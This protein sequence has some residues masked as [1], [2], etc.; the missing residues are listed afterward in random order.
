MHLLKQPLRISTD[1]SNN[2]NQQILNINEL[3][4]CFLIQ[5]ETATKQTVKMFHVLFDFD[6]TLY[7][8]TE[9]DKIA[10]AKV[11]NYI[12]NIFPIE[13]HEVQIIYK[14]IVSVI[15]KSNNINNKHDKEIY[16]KKICEHIGVPLYRL[17]AI[18]DLY[19]TSF[20]KHLTLTK[21]AD[22]LLQWRDFGRGGVGLYPGG[23][24]AIFIGLA[25]ATRRN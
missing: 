6:D 2:T 14:N 25:L 8:F 19:D 23:R 16:F 18:M 22:D 3:K 1:S 10:C 7:N 11:F 13:S 20:Y 9:C 4:T 17:P 24:N 12:A 15:K 5:K 21:G